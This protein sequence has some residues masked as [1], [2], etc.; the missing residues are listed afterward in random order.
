MNIWICVILN[1]DWVGTFSLKSLRNQ[2]EFIFAVLNN[3]CKTL[4]LGGVAVLFYYAHQ[5]HLAS[6]AEEQNVMS[7]TDVGNETNLPSVPQ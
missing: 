4:P 3:V 5:R 2:T 7:R 1:L 6:A